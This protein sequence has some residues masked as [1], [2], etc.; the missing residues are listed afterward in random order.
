MKRLKRRRRARTKRG[1]PVFVPR[2]ERL[3]DRLLLA[4]YESFENVLGSEW[5]F[6][7]VDPDAQVRVLDLAAEGIIT[8]GPSLEY[9][10]G[11][12][13]HALAFD[14]SDE[15]SGK[16]LGIAI[17]SIDISAYS[18][19][20]LTFHQ[21]EHEQGD[22]D[23][24]LPEKHPK[25]EPGDGIAISD[26]GNDWYTLRDRNEQGINRSGDGLWMLRQI[27]LGRELE[28]INE[29]YPDANIKFYDNLR[30]KFSQYDNL[31]LPDDGWAIDEIRIDQSTP[32][33]TSNRPSGAYHRFTL[34][35][36]SEDDYYFR[37]AFFGNVGSNS[38]ILVSQHGSTG[39][40]GNGHATRW[41]T[42]VRDNYNAIDSLI[43]VTPV[44]DREG[45]FRTEHGYGQLSWNDQTDA[46]A[47]LALLETVDAIAVSGFG[48]ASKLYLWGFSE[49][50]Q[51]VIRFAAAHPDRVAAGVVGSPASLPLPTESV[52]WKYG[53]GLR[54]DKL[55][56]PE[57]EL[58]IND[59]LASRLMFWIGGL[60]LVVGSYRRR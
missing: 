5:S 58:N 49:G 41:Q 21:Y 31:S 43:V 13:N 11:G 3:E 57:V 40:F 44:F 26:D 9:T 1:T 6:M 24:D 56:P 29:A 47:D 4:Y 19:A 34:A 48:D 2:V 59:A 51:F 18:D 52:A 54:H 60:R 27:D 8:A 20:I 35:N 45:R 22:E 55:P 53:F 25:D 37:V 14:S 7:S 32:A 46:A 10:Q 42:Y 36:E 39:E 15:N 50:G 17:L 38:P 28:R 16:D 23:D 33:F 12:N 30:L